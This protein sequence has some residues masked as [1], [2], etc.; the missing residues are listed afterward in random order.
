MLNWNM[1]SVLSVLNWNPKSVLSV[2][3]WKQTQTHKK[4]I[5]YDKHNMRMFGV[6]PFIKKQN[7][8]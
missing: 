7:D 6:I 2:P 3:Y 5:Y 8:T 4:A 1:E